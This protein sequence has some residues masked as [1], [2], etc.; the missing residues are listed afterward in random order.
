M[1]PISSSSGHTTASFLRD[2]QKS[3]STGGYRNSSSTSKL[4]RSERWRATFGS[5][6]LE[7]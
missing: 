2:V 6:R 4:P 5:D 1:A 7:Q 3:I